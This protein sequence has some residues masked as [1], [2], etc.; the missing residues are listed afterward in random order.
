VLH[1][2]MR[3]EVG[4]GPGPGVASGDQGLRALVA[5]LDGELA[6][7]RRALEAVEARIVDLAKLLEKERTDRDV[8]L[9]S[10]SHEL[11]STIKSLISRIDEGL[12]A[13]AASLRE[14]TNE[15]EA[16]LKSL[17]SRVDQGLTAGAAALQDSLDSAGAEGGRAPGGA[18][19]EGGGP[20]RP[21]EGPRP[22]APA[23]APGLAGRQAARPT[24]AAVSAQAPPSP[25]ATFRDFA[26]GGS[27]PRGA[28]P[29]LGAGAPA[30]GCASPHSAV[31]PQKQ[32]PV[33]AAAYSRSPS[34]NKLA[35]QDANP[36]RL[37]QT[38]DQLQQE[39]RRL[40]E[41]RA[42]L[43]AAS[44]TPGQ[45]VTPSCT[46]SLAFP[47]TM[48]VPGSGLNHSSYAASSGGESRGPSH[49]G[50][51]MRVGMSPLTVAAHP[52]GPRMVGRH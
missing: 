41:R 32:F 14:K 21:G 18:K 16:L 23:A 50:S 3:D 9:R 52:A 45:G 27:L 46:P 51:P 15:T 43:Q 5:R 35:G 17:I 20:W 28:A 1:R 4:D 7:E 40:R 38:F 29:P 10:F 48:Q 49:L 30:Q 25:T 31:L 22:A 26:A 12:S 2:R 19:S 37:L 44:A 34:R 36:D 39:N 8:Q 6:A 13:G 11:D 33:A 24:S 42:Q 47:T